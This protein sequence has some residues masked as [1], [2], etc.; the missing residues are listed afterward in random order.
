MNCN[1]PKS[2]RR[3]IRTAAASTAELC[4]STRSRRVTSVFVFI[5]L[6]ALNGRIKA[7]STRSGPRQNFHLPVVRV[8]T[9]GR[10]IR[11]QAPCSS[12]TTTRLPSTAVS[13]GDEF[14][15]WEVGDVYQ[16]LE[17]LEK[18]ITLQKAD[19][20]LQ[21]EERMEMLRHLATARRPILPDVSRYTL[22]PLAAALFLRMV[23]PPTT[24]FSMTGVER[25]PFLL[26]RSLTGI[27]NLQFWTTV[28]VAPIL[29]LTVKR[30]TLPEPEPMPEELKRLDPSLLKFLTIVVDYEPPEKS[31]RD[32]VLFLLEYWT[33]AVATMAILG[34]LQI[35][36]ANPWS[37]APSRYNRLMGSLSGAMVGWMGVAQ[38]FTRVGAVAAL[39]QNPRQVFQL[40]R[41]GQPR[42]KAF[43]PFL[44]EGLI[45]NMIRILPLGLATDLF[46]VL[47]G[48]PNDA[49]VSL[50]SSISVLGIGTWVRLNNRQREESEDGLSVA[51][52]ER[53]GRRKRMMY[54]FSTLVLWKRSIASWMRR[55]QISLARVQQWNQ[56]PILQALP[57]IKRALVRL[58]TWTS[59]GVF[60]L[61][62]PLL[63]IRSL[64]KIVRII[65]THDVSLALDDKD[66]MEAFDDESSLRSRMKWRYRLEWRDDEDTE[67]IGEIFRKRRKSFWYWLFLEGKV[68]DQLWRESKRNLKESQRSQEW[69]IM[70]RIP[71]DMRTIPQTQIPHEEWKT[72]A[73]KRIAEKHQQDYDLKDFEDPL[74]VAL[75]QTLGIG[76]GFSF[77]HD[78]PLQKGK[79]PSA[80]K[81]QARAAKSAIRH[82]QQLYDA[83]AKELG[84]IS[85]PE[86]RKARSLE[87]GKNIEVERRFLAARM[88]ELV[89]ISDENSDEFQGRTL[90]QRFQQKPESYVMVSPH[91][92]RMVDPM[93]AVDSI[94]RDLENFSKESSSDYDDYRQYEQNHSTLKN[95]SE[96]VTSTP[97]DCESDNGDEA[98]H[99]DDE[100]LDAYIRQQKSTLSGVDDDDNDTDIMLA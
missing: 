18:A 79:K 90:I 15:E 71:D 69:N 23:A 57:T 94:E 73:M 19:Q 61:T 59:A 55:H 9:R 33:S 74:G 75:Q 14:E 66:F 32:Y 24:A 77:D 25:I 95:V 6:S 88:I 41:S 34:F 62:A 42:P 99:Q 63:H 31:C 52:L 29:L 37:A 83:S 4:K 98:P 28:V 44:L 39:Y 8:P 20:N 13:S 40:R 3:K 86:A 65:Y 85:D 21:H 67:R 100:F 17:L 76:L 92:F 82:M 72:I 38:L 26:V 46:Q 81:L 5:I 10:P 89:P 47:V 7:F 56:T 16:D 93:D 70:D 58:L 35:L 22:V 2:N 91:E 1:L 48:L 87:I 50:Y 36:G 97:A 64:A 78:T 68:S 27:M 80:R 84:A 53:L 60:S 12:T 45:S 43:F 51:Q 96:T 54:T 30:L 11:A 49:L